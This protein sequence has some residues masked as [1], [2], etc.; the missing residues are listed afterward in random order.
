M[1][2]GLLWAAFGLGVFGS[3]CGILVGF[4][5]RPTAR[6]EDDKSLRRYAI[7]G[8]LVLL[9]ILLFSMLRNKPFTVG[10]MLGKSGF[11]GGL[12][13]L[14]A[15]WSMV[16]VWSANRQAE[17]ASLRLLSLLTPLLYASLTLSI[18]MIW[19]RVSLYDAF[20]G[21]LIGWVGVSLPLV[22]GL[23]RG[24]V[25]ERRF[26][27]P[28]LMG[29]G[30][31]LTFAT[32]LSIAED[33]PHLIL[34]GGALVVSW[35]TLLLLLGSALPFLV[36]V[37]TLFHAQTVRILSQVK[38]VRFAPRVFGRLFLSED[39]PLIGAR[40]GQILLSGLLLFG[41]SRWI[42]GR[43]D[44]EKEFSLL[45]LLGMGT[46][47]LI[48]WLHADLLHKEPKAGTGWQT[49]MLSVLILIGMMMFTY[50]WTHN[51]GVG[52]ALIGMWLPLAFA[53]LTNLIPKTE[54]EEES[55]TPP[56]PLAL[57]RI[58][59]FGAALYAYQFYE[60]RFAI[61]SSHLTTTNEHYRLCVFVIGAAI[62]MLLTQWLWRQKPTA[63]RTVLSGAIA[64][65]VPAL[66]ILLF[67]S[68]IAVW[69]FWGGVF[70]ILFSELGFPKQT[71]EQENLTL[72]REAVLL[73]ALYG[74]ISLV[75]L[76]EWADYILQFADLKKSQR[77]RL[78]AYVVGGI[79]ALVLASDYGTRWR[80]R[81][82]GSDRKGAN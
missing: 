26:T 75:V 65:A 37:T 67:R 53:I 36:I 80:E 29:L 81:K 74:I 32:A 4:R 12:G 61:H 17:S 14:V 57:L 66:L 38:I 27:L 60:F 11:C 16:R 64:I 52:I 51:T 24:K 48:W 41:L 71:E 73:P 35:G 70:S 20:S 3:L 2:K 45:L 55:P 79:F 77:L 59:L 13:A 82:N 10:N 28:L 47:V 62:P 5:S 68:E 42:Q 30:Y 46:G 1:D 22:V 72:P 25:E 69:L 44:M 15:Y 18:A 8:L 6:H 31:L 19:F 33:H 58:T 39:A 34:K 78:L 63:L 54:T 50:Q 21:L 7:A 9:S 43:L 23:L 76:N 56:L 40:V 49:S